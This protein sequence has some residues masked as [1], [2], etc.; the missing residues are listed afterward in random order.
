MLRNIKCIKYVVKPARILV[1]RK[2][3]FARFYVPMNT[4]VTSVTTTNNTSFHISL[5]RIKS[6]SLS[7]VFKPY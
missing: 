6:P 1:L 3:P 5:Q 2:L 7:K 4:V